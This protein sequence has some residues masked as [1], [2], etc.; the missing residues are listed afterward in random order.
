MLWDFLLYAKYESNKIYASH[1]L[2]ETVLLQKGNIKNNYCYKYTVKYSHTLH[3]SRFYVKNV[4]KCQLQYGFPFSFS[5][6]YSVKY[7]LLKE[8]RKNIYSKNV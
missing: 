8:S 5:Q 2:Q 7:F 1:K 6:M 3:I 4:T